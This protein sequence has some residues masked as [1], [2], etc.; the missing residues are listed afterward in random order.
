MTPNEP[1]GYQNN[2]LL[3]PK[4]VAQKFTPEQIKEILIC[5]ADP[6]YFIRKY[7]KIVNVDR[8][9][10]LFD[11]HDYQERMI[12]LFSFSRFVI[13]KCPRQVGKTSCSAAYLLWEA[14]FHSDKTIGIFANKAET[15]REILS[16]VALMFQ[17]LPQWLQQGVV[18]WNKGDIEFENRSQI[19][20][21]AVASSAARGYSFTN[22]LLD[23][24]AF[25]P[26]NIQQEFFTSV[27]PTISSGKT[28]KVIVTSTP[29]GI[30]DWFY[31]LWKGA[32]NETNDFKPF[33]IN[34]WDHPERD[35][36]WKRE[37]I[38]NTSEEQF[39][40]EHECVIGGT[41]IRLK[42]KDSEF[43]HKIS[44]KEAHDKFMG[45]WDEDSTIKPNTNDWLI[46]TGTGIFRPFTGI[47]KKKPQKELRKIVLK[48]GF[49]LVCS[50]D[51]QIFTNAGWCRAENLSS[52]MYVYTYNNGEREAH[53]IEA[54]IPVYHTYTDELY[55]PLNCEHYISNGF[56]S[57]NCEFLGSANTLINP[58]KIATLSHTKPIYQKD[59]MCLY[60]KPQPHRLYALIADVARGR[61]SHGVGDCSAFVLFDVT[62]FPFRVVGTFMDNEVPPLYFPTII[63]PIAKQYN[64]CMVLI[65]NKDAGGQVCDILNHEYAYEHVLSTEAMGRRGQIL[66]GGTGKRA[67]LGV[68]TSAA[69]KALGCSNFKS[70]VEQDK[71]IIEDLELIS[72][73]STFISNGKGSFEAEI[74]CYDD[75]V[76]C[77]VLF[78]WMI[79]QQYFKDQQKP[80]LRRDIY[81]DRIKQHTEEVM[82]FGYVPDDIYQSFGGISP[83]QTENPNEQIVATWD[84]EGNIHSR[85]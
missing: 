39:S 82:P 53:Y 70:L 47:L 74:G 20:A 72:Q 10:M 80:D 45:E 49:T 24:F 46:E 17:Y 29:N 38:R 28:T 2:K 81:K 6:I 37:Q 69:V 61:N 43:I 78:A 13:T 58:K 62:E 44:I 32:E 41:L 14:V 52:D 12:N 84:I 21:F 76:M 40:Q 33:S 22:I 57:H 75:L 71:I 36:K 85:W 5:K 16:R 25:V 30:G 55:D 34:W 63:Y 64:N 11:L 23:E 9:L 50:T 73:I 51:H 68:S 35:D 42:K 66:T 7:V 56:V 4:G 83:N 19:I 31:K 77:C 79:D 26:R 3:K 8:G 27:Y 67:V 18:T 59:G 65:E 1:T 15:A 48:N 54:L 60:E